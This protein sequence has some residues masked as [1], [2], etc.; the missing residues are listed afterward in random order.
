MFI[1]PALHGCFLVALELNKLVGVDLV[2][3]W[4]VEEDVLAFDLGLGHGAR[5]SSFDLVQ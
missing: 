5:D 4:V 1:G 3:V 2:R